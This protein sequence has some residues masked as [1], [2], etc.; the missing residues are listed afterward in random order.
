LMAAAVYFTRDLW[1]PSP[2][3]IRPRIIT[4]GRGTPF[5]TIQAA[6]AE[7]QP[8][9]TVDV[10][11]GEYNEPIQLKTGIS[12]KSHAPLQAI[13]RSRG[14]QAAPVM[15]LVQGVK[16]ARFSGFRIA[17]DPAAPIAAGILVIESNLAVEETEIEGAGVGI[18]IRGASRASLV[19]NAVHDCLGEGL[20]MTGPVEA[21]VSHNSF[22]RN[23][24]GLVG[25]DGA[26]PTLVGNVFE[27]NPILLPPEIPME[28]L[29]EHNFI[30]D[31]RPAARGRKNE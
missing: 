29:R 22:Q 11:A 19:G 15:V 14:A 28:T 21:W 3:I 16:D 12:V 10:L 31:A 4:A 13:L 30:L 5:A 25:R 1:R 9:D 26:R 8:G 20:L 6:I 2:V 23:K 24:T 17:A 7:A 18:E 27:K